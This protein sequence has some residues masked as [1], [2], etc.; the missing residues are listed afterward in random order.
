MCGTVG[1][2]RLRALPSWSS[3]PAHAKFPSPVRVGVRPLRIAV[4]PLRFRGFAHRSSVRAIPFFARPQR[5]GVC[6]H[7]FS[8]LA[9]QW[10]MPPLRRARQEKRRDSTKNQ[11]A[12]PRV[13]WALPPQQRARQKFR[14]YHTKNQRAVPPH[15]RAIRPLQWAI[16]ENGRAHPKNQRGDRERRWAGRG[17]PAGPALRGDV[18]TWV[19][20]GRCAET[21]WDVST[22]P[23]TAH[24]ISPCGRFRSP[25]NFLLPRS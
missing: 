22:A 17:G 25:R 1:C 15:W 18:P 10:A 16:P 13:Q 24:Q 7:W 4:A 6:A 21:D 11:R 2:G 5:R 3:H 9:L 23:S 14:R 19:A 12:T 20:C 8:V